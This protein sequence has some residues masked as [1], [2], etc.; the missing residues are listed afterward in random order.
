MR[1]VVA[2]ILLACSL[3]LTGCFH[4][5]SVAGPDMRAIARGA[6][7]VRTVE[8]PRVRV[9]PNSNVR[10]HRSDG[11]TTPWIKAGDLVVNDDGVMLAES[12]GRD[13]LRWGD[14]VYSEVNNT[15]GGYTVLVVAGSAALIALIVAAIAAGSDA[16][17]DV[18]GCG[19]CNGFTGCYIGGHSHSHV[20]YYPTGEYP[21]NYDGGPV[22]RSSKGIDEAR[23]PPQNLPDPALGSYGLDLPS[24]H[25]AQPLFNADENRRADVGFT[26]FAEGGA[27]HYDPEY[28]QTS[29]GGGFRFNNMWE[30]GGGVTRF[31]G[32][33]DAIVGTDTMYPFVR[34]GLHN[35]LDPGRFVA[36]PTSV[37]VGGL[38]GRATHVRFIYGVQVRISPFNY[39]G[40]YPA[41]VVFRRNEKTQSDEWT[42]PTTLEFGAIF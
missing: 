25:N 14:V 36:I 27:L 35:D 4:T 34:L 18:D 2:H 13:G 8:G 7:S 5:R 10:F 32:P 19:N 17:V 38:P 1:F 23:L 15:S 42:A 41:N 26:V 12:Y 31:G 24:E 33:G 21:P 40:I 20:D 9:D 30:I 11:T 3:V 37:E 16:D 22:I 39:I 29:L 6:K 28:F